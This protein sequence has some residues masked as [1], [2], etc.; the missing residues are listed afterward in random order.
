MSADIASQL[1]FAREIH[2]AMVH[3]DLKRVVSQSMAPDE[4][5]RR[6]ETMAAIVATLERQQMLA[7]VSEEMAEM[8][9]GRVRELH[10]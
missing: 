5:A 2:S 6:N 3:A 1:K 9:G 10:L 7:E 4:A 8:W